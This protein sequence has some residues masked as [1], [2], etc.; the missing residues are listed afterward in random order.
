[1]K[2]MPNRGGLWCVVKKKTI[3][4]GDDWLAAGVHGKEKKTV[5]DGERC[6]G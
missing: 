4:I 5:E 1:M 2:E 6:S 3:E